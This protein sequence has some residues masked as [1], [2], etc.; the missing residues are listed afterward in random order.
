MG[1]IFEETFCQRMYMNDQEGHERY[2]TSLVIRKMQICTRGQYHTYSRKWLKLKKLPIL[3][4]GMNVE[5][6]KFSHIA[7][8]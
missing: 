6:L 5:Q 1:K 8:E 7:G 4:V 2:P 3:N